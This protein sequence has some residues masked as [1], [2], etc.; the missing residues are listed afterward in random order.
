MYGRLLQ[1]E[2]LSGYDG[3]MLI[4]SETGADHA[5]IAELNRRA[6]GGEL[7]AELIDR[8]RAEKL[9][10]SS[11]VSVDAYDRIL[12]HILFSRVIIQTKPQPT[13]GTLSAPP[14]A[15]ASL[16]PMCVAPEMQRHGIG[17]ALVRHGIR[18]CRRMDQD[19]IIV[20]GHPTF[21]SE[22]G[23]TR[24]VVRHLESPYAGEAFMGLELVPGALS[25]I[26]GQVVYP[27]AFAVFA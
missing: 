22:M 1:P 11:L 9:V 15:V 2:Q 16:G 8:L 19:A 26:R 10:L 17:S 18:A 12:G 20:V 25:S 21:C 14:V 23:F 5:V 4:R 13:K 24:E 6:F 3:V 7:E 27:S